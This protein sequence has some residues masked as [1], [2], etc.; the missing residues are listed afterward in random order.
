M[1]QLKFDFPGSRAKPDTIL[2]ALGNVHKLHNVT[3]GGGVFARHDIVY[4]YLKVC[5]MR[6]KGGGENLEE[7]RYIICK[8][9]LKLSEKFNAPIHINC[10][11]K[12]STG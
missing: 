1:D 10:N 7:V 4:S 2:N 5:D 3:T 12:D 8:R 9:F 6:W 11:C